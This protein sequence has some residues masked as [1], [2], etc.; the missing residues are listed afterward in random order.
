M[1]SN[2]VQQF[3]EQADRSG[4]F[5]LETARAALAPMTLDADVSTDQVAARLIEKKLLTTYQ[6]EQLLAGRGEDC[7]VAG[8]YQILQKLGEGGMGAVYKARDSKLDRVVALKVLPAGRLNDADAVAR[9]QREAK[10]LARLGHPHIIQAYDSGDDRGRHFLVMEFVEGIALDKVLR[11]YGALAPTLAAD[12]IYQTALGLAHAHERGLI[13]RDVKPANVLV[14]GLVSP[15][16]AIPAGVG[17]TVDFADTPAPVRLKPGAASVKLLDLGLARFL[18]DQL[19]D[20]QLTQEGAGMGTPDYMAP[21]QF[22]DALHADARTDIYGL[23]C[24]AYHLLTGQVPFPGTSFSEKA[25]AHAKK[26]PIPLEERC[27]EVPAGLAA[28]VQKMMAKHPKERF[29]S[30]NDV[31]D[32]MA[33]FVAGASQ[34]MIRLRETGKWP[35][36]QST[37]LMPARGKRLIAGASAVATSALALCMMV[38]LWPGLFG[39]GPTIVVQTKPPD[40]PPV[41]LPDDPK[42][43]EPKPAKPT[44]VT[45]ENGVTVAKDGT[46]QFTTI[47][48]ALEKIK[49]KQT[50]RILDD[51]VYR[52]VIQLRSR[53]KFD[54][55]TLESPRHATLEFPPEAKL[56]VLITN[57]PSVTVRGLRIHTKTTGTTC[58]GVGGLCP[59]TRLEDLTCSSENVPRTTGMSLDSVGLT[60]QDEPMRV[61]HCN[62]TALGNGIELIGMNMATKASTPLRRV[63]ICDNRFQDC[64]VGIWTLGQLSEIHIIGNRFWN[65]NECGIRLADL[66][67]ASGR[68]LIANNTI[69]GTRNCIEIADP[70]PSVKGVEIRNNITVAESSPDISY[71]GKTPSLSPDWVLANNWRKGRRPVKGTPDAEQL[72]DSPADTFTDKLPLESLNSSDANFLR[73]AKDSPLT[74]AGKGDDLPAYVGALPPEGTKPWDWQWTWDAHIQ[75]LITVSLKPNDGGRFRTIAAALAVVS[76]N[77][78]IRVLD[79]E[80]YSESLRLDRPELHKGVRLVAV[81]NATLAISK[82]VSTA[83]VVDDV[84]DVHIQGFRFKGQEAVRGSTFIRIRQNASGVTLSDLDFQATE[85]VAGITI[86]NVAVADSAAPLIVRK[87]KFRV[88]YDGISVMGPRGKGTGKSVSS[89]IRIEDNRLLGCLRGIHIE[90]AV[91]DMLVAGNV[92]TGCLQEGIG[93]ANLPAES[94]RVLIVNNTLHQCA[95]GLRVWDDPPHNK[96]ARGQVEFRANICLEGENADA[97]YVQPGRIG[98]KGSPTPG[99]GQA[100]IEAWVFADNRRDL[101]GNSPAHVLPLA[102]GDKK[103]DPNDLESREWSDANFLRPRLKSALATGGAGGDRPPSAG[104]VPPEGAPAWN[105]KKV[106]GPFK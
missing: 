18:Q 25:H 85:M 102:K 66:K 16:P 68:L 78:T 26:E 106:S 90:G 23:G 35:P 104:A 56:G 61:I 76:P 81:K 82:D 37:M 12:L 20:A 88:G 50:I 21:E 96:L 97:G 30:A 45:I 72:A 49:P 101:T 15:A 48:A 22:R 44:V 51:A 29:Q 41:K 60:P 39:L 57:V 31:A 52:E 58:V 5:A 11:Q 34:S 83:L 65:S 70:A 33:P 94:R 74:N 14:A 53:E 47:A 71:T 67:D 42:V 93:I 13:H 80:T 36:G 10:A 55:I 89:R 100:L 59:G 77:M 2:A 32:A 24:T 73:P 4:L 46:G 7:V 8:R 91:A 95:F 28:I 3:L 19:G 27:P 40:D 63:L 92:A 43:V 79:G 105:W 64:F 86:D 9:F 17:P 84:P 38:F 6:A 69:Q 87:C 99:D 103:L 98:V 1:P 54:G 62:F 75:K